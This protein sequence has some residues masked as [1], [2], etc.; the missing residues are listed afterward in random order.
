MTATLLWSELAA[1][2]LG[3]S[4]SPVHVAVVL[5]LLTGSRPVQRAGWFVLG[6]LA[7][8]ALAVAVLLTIG[9]GLVLDMGRGSVHRTGLD[10]LAAGA[11]AA[12]GLRELLRRGVSDELPGWTRSLDRFVALPLPVLL[13][14]SAVTELISP[15]NLVLLAKAAG[16][17]LAA[18]LPTGPESLD[19][20]LFS[21][22]AGWLL[23]LPL[24]A[25]VLLR[26]R[27]TPVLERGRLWLFRHGDGVVGA[28]SLVLAG[29]LGWQGVA[30]L[31]AG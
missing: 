20:A 25:V 19:T 30:G 24:L 13:A 4:L 16:A 1:Y 28:L 9:H 23:L 2:G 15:D 10:L 11:L 7:T 29:Y 18:G 14:L 22:V 12:L 5:L 3:I 6:W 21:L 31:Q 17:L 8:T 27:A 26:E